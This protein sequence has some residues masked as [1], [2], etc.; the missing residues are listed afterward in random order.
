VINAHDDIN[1][2]WELTAF[3]GFSMTILFCRFIIMLTEIYLILWSINAAS[4]K[5]PLIQAQEGSEEYIQQGFD[6]DNKPVDTERVGI[7]YD[8][9]IHKKIQ[10]NN[11]SKVW[12]NPIVGQVDIMETGS[13]LQSNRKNR[14]SSNSKKKIKKRR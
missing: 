8:E 14:T 13:R 2:I 7:N 1:P 9:I 11:N 12:G 6:I 10:S 5:K 4:T 3:W